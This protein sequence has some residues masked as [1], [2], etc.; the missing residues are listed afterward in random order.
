MIIDRREDMNLVELIEELYLR[1]D[2]KVSYFENKFGDELEAIEI[3]DNESALYDD[4]NLQIQDL[5]DELE[6]LLRI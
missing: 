4:D 5:R 1:F 6:G 3:T 2:D